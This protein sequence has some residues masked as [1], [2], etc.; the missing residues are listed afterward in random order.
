MIKTF[1]ENYGGALFNILCA[2]FNLYDLF[3]CNFKII[4]SWNAKIKT[5]DK[6]QEN[7]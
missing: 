7:T 2:Y 6:R 1:F 5:V 3:K 4:F